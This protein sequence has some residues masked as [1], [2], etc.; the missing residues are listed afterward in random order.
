M[1]KASAKAS[2]GAPLYMSRE[3]ETDLTPSEVS[4]KLTPQLSSSFIIRNLLIM[5][6]AAAAAL[7]GKAIAEEF[8]RGHPSN[9]LF[10]E[11]P[12]P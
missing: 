6:L 10:S 7:P 3:P 2:A 11:E 1:E 8:M 12:P 4:E 9:S 5:A